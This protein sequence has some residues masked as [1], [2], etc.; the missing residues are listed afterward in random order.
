MNIK[1][2]I[3][4]VTD[5]T[6]H[7]LILELEKG[8]IKIPR[9]QRD[10]I[11]E[12]SK[13]IKLFN[14]ILSQYPIGSIFLWSAPP[15]YKNFIRKTEYLEFENKNE[16]NKC[17][18][19]IDGQ[20]RI[21]S[22]YATLRGKKVGKT[23]YSKICFN[24]KKKDLVVPRKKIEKFNIPVC[25]VFNNEA[26]N[27][28]IADL[29]KYDASH[30]TK[31][32]NAW[33]E[34]RN[35]LMNYPISIVKTLNNDLEDVVEIFERINQGGNRLTLFDL[36][37]ATVLDNKFDLKNNIE[38]V[39]KQAQ[40]KK[41]GGLPN[42]LI[43]NSLA[44]N[45]FENCSSSAQLKLTS[46]ICQKIWDPT[47]ESI[48]ATI[49]FLMSIGIQTDLVQ[50]HSLIPVL[51]YYFYNTRFVVIHPTHQKQVEKWFWDSKFSNRYAHSNLSKIKEDVQWI[52]KLTED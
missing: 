36:V 10:Y 17:D 11:W 45:A 19:I 6:L 22:L 51:Q 40:I 32:V 37:H 44:I 12:R 31:Y 46:V 48:N 52:K 23:D 3:E 18:F 16:N 9:F 38:K 39:N 35:I 30:K 25:T 24:V 28:I 21:V 5:W 42:R 14:S 27:E 33:E 4:I 15:K 49:E 41:I 20:Q 26:Y 13:V 1:N 47:I 2:S 50:Y 34:F 7:K 29:K 8:H 43:V